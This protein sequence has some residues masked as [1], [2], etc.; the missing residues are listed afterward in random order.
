MHGIL[1]FFMSSIQFNLKC[2][3]VNLTNGFH[4]AVR[5]FNI[6]SQLTTKC[7]K[8]KKTCICGLDMTISASCD[9]SVAIFTTSLESEESY[10]T[11]RN[12][13]LQTCLLITRDFPPVQHFRTA[14]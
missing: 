3:N 6:R 10:R 4:V 7:G 8:N 11:L 14:L 12:L 5:L 9:W 2:L 13:T 1:I